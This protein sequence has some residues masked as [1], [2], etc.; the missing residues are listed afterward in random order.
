M[1]D[2]VPCKRSD[3]AYKD[4]RDRHYIPNKGCQGQQVHYLILD[5]GRLVGIISG[6]AATMKSIKNARMRE[7]FDIAPV[8]KGEKNPVLN[9][10]ISNV[11]F[12]LETNYPN[13]ATRVLARWRRIA[14]EDWLYLYQVPVIGFETYVIQ[15]PEEIRNG[16]TDRLGTLYKADNWSFLGY[17]KGSAKA[18]HARAGSG[19][20]TAK[21]T[22]VPTVVKAIWA[23]KTKQRKRITEYRS[24]WRGDDP[25]HAR[26]VQH[27]RLIWLNQGD[28]TG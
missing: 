12:R 15:T 13:L 17:T 16:L 23:I 24:S 18:H 20:L 9:Q 26:A 2:L 25:E 19:G 7:F 4:I 28:R 14:A 1:I 10:I 11:V 22:R 3:R 6:A 5:N 21:H 8:P 27:R